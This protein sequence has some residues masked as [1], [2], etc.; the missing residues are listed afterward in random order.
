MS[1]GDVLQIRGIRAGL[2]PQ[3]KIEITGKTKGETYSLRHSL[4]PRQV[5][6]IRMGGLVNVARTRS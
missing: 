3:E 1:Q 2:R 5:E 4:G 6:I